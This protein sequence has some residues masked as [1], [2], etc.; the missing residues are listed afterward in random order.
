MPEISRFFGMI[1][2]MYWDEHNPPH[3][4]VL[5]ED[6]TAVIDINGLKIIEGTLSRRALNIVLDWAE[7]HQNEL[8]ENWE[9]CKKKKKPKKIKPLR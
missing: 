6:K 2:Q 7:I 3:F 8:L 4:H 5:Y 1:I 9:L